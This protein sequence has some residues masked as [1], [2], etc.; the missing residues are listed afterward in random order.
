MQVTR[1]AALAAPFLMA[2]G[3]AA[4]R[5]TNVVMFMTDDHGAWAT[6]AYGCGEMRTPN[7]D[8]LAAG[9]ARFDRAYACTP[10]CSPSR[11]TWLT[12]KLPSQHGV[13]DWL[14][15]ADSFGAE[16]R[17]FLDG[18]Q[19]YSEI[20]AANGYTLGLAGKWHMG[21]DDRAQRGF[22]FWHTVPG[23]GGTFRDPE[24]VTNGERRK[25]QGFKTDLVTDG[26]L[27]FL[28]TVR[29]KPF[30][31]LMPFYAPHTPYDFQPDPDRAPY[32]GSKF[33]CFP[34]DERH[35]WQNTGLAQHHRNPKSKHAYSALI[36]AVDRNVGRVLRKLE[37]MGVRGNTL[38]IFTADQG[39]NAGQHG[40][41]GKGNG[42]IPYNMYEESIRV[43][44]IWN[45][46]E[47]VKSGVVR[48]MVSSYDYF[49][50]LLEY[51]GLP[52]PK[53]RQPLPGRSYAGLL[54]GRRVRWNNR[55]YFE[56][57]Y[58]RAVRTD[59]LKYVERIREWPSELYD[60]EADPG[61]KRNLL[62]A[63]GYAKQLATLRA[64]LSG[65][66]ARHGAPPLEQ[67]RSTTQQRLTE[68]RRAGG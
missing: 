11:M 47:R 63:P 36:S 37:E 49:P 2:R 18:H 64:D 62:D 19:T 57:G 41:W 30:Y 14:I 48:E 32:N 6:G 8:R 3:R 50:T 55:L 15:P 46:P 23:G 17:P 26:A 20:L 21:Q 58:T 4:S 9:G 12:G 51:L 66:F 40:M 54:D 39:W 65:F 29:D 53:P 10:V 24:F 7:I 27:Q 52:A 28:D 44:L 16:A 61:E 13:Q 34:D 68:Y 38:V 59:N 67:W 5:R 45:H 31:L 60:L 35:P 22:S 42:T 56:Y 1:R 25:L 43:P 33:T